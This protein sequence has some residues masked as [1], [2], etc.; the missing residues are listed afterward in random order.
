MEHQ[1]HSRFQYSTW[2]GPRPR[3][4]ASRREAAFGAVS[5]RQPAAG[6]ICGRAGLDSAKDPSYDYYGNNRWLD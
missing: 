3:A 4:R 2:L 5:A 6:R 1:E